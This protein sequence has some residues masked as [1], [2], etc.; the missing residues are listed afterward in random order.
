MQHR[1]QDELVRLPA[2]AKR[3]SHVEHVIVRHSPALA[4]LTADT[5]ADAL[6]RAG[7]DQPRGSD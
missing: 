4:A 1:F 5:H 7:L 6:I 3:L 2:K